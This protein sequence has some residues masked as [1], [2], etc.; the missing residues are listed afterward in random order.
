MTG[1]TY[2]NILAQVG[3]IS[4]FNEFCVIDILVG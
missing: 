2:F 3:E 4:K 1:I